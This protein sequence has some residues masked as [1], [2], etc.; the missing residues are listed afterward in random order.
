MSSNIICI[1][2]NK[3]EKIARKLAQ[4][5]FDGEIKKADPMQA[6]DTKV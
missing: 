1:D 3:I 5:I 4:S 6:R 2:K